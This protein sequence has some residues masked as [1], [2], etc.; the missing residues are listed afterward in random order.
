MKGQSERTP[1]V[2]KV[3]QARRRLLTALLGSGGVVALGAVAG[4]ASAADDVK[5]PGDEPTH[6]IVYQF[7]EAENSYH[8]HVLG[9]VSAMLREYT[10]D[11]HVVVSCFAEGIHIV[12]K[13]PG[14]PVTDLIKQ[15]VSSL[16]DYGVEFHACART[17][18]SLQWTAEDLLPFVKVVSAGAADLMALQE[19]G[20]AYVAW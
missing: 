19:K 9:S 7:N 20:Y 8:E 13:K 12:A 5:F 17:M 15:R 16:A 10:D 6:K 11:I 3:D 4:R 14:R 1:W 18:E 2:A